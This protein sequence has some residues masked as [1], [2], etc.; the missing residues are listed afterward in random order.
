MKTGANYKKYIQ[1]STN[2]FH[3]SSFIPEADTFKLFKPYFAAT[4]KILLL[5]TLENT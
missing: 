2:N 5:H 4:D 3:I 1:M